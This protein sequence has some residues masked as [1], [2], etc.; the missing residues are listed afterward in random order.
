MTRT[1]ARPAATVVEDDRPRPASARAIDVA[2]IYWLETRYEFIKL[3][4]LP[5][6]SIPTITFP[7]MFYALFGLSFGTGRSAGPVTMATYLIPTYGAFGVIGAA[8]F[9]LGVGVAIERGQGW[10]LLKRATPMPPL[11]YFAAKGAMSL[12]FGA[13]IITMLALLGIFF[14]NVRLE[15]S[16]WARLATALVLGAVPFCALGLA[17]GYF[18]G[19]NAAPAIVNIIYLPM[20]FASGMW[21]PIEFLP[22]FMQSLAPWLPAYHLSQLALA[23]I[24]ASRGGPVLAH[25]AA[26]TGFTACCLALALIGYR[27][28]EGKTYG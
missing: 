10:L 9:G 20:G 2:R 26:L 18:A 7:V 14:G 15:P 16:Q 17:I 13:I 27:R 1:L 23:S 6:Y 5:A 4:R 8:L 21:I 28:D 11:A 22:R 3:L 19:P 25:V 24:G 12:I